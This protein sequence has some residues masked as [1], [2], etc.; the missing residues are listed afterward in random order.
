MAVV[1]CL[2]TEPAIDYTGHFIT[3]LEISI[4]RAVD[5]VTSRAHPCAY[6]QNCQ[7]PLSSRGLTTLR[8]PIRAQSLSDCIRSIPL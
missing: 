8:T 6:Q 2:L 4:I 1:D 5:L 7:I 3:F